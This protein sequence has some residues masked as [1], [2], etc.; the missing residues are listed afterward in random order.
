MP[1]AEYTL[2]LQPQHRPSEHLTA[3]QRA[4]CANCMQYTLTTSP[5]VY[6]WEIYTTSTPQPYAVQVLATKYSTTRATAARSYFTRI[7]AFPTPDHIS[8]IDR[9]LRGSTRGAKE[10]V[11]V[12]TDRQ[13]QTAASTFLEAQRRNIGTSKGKTTK[14]GKP[15]KKTVGFMPPQIPVDRD[16]YDAV[17]VAVTKKR[18]G[19]GGKARNLKGRRAWL[20]AEMDVEDARLQNVE[21]EATVDVEDEEET[22][23]EVMGQEVMGQEYLATLFPDASFPRRTVDAGNVLGGALSD[24]VLR[25]MGLLYDSDEEDVRTIE[26]SYVGELAGDEPGDGSDDESAVPDTPLVRAAGTPAPELE[27]AMDM[28]ELWVIIGEQVVRVARPVEEG[29]DW[30]V[31]SEL[32]LLRLV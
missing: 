10:K 31:V 16:G 11:Q 27:A 22:E 23:E 3:W 29:T 7:P 30:D 13:R 14:R 32:S 12:L 1:R 4:Y 8:C 2:A 20:D 5:E 24:E 15:N 18:N 6:P 19:K 28:D 17:L 25:E 9:R 26:R 21:R